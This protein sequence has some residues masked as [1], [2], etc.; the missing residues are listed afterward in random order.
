RVRQVITTLAGEP[1]ALR[2]ISLVPYGAH[3]FDRRTRD[4]PVQAHAWLVPPDQALAV[5]AR[6]EQRGAT[7]AGHPGA[8]QVEDML[9]EVARMLRTDPGRA[10]LL[11]V[12]AHGPHPPRADVSQIL[13]CPARHDWD[14]LLR[15]L[16]GRP[17]MRF[18]AICDDS[19]ASHE[20]WRRLGG[21]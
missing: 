20:V 21:G 9:A 4:E 16:E 6:I 17:G 12:G 8:A 3:S 1:R 2:G 13:P 7:A 18:L 11:S 10:A 15:Y 19:P 14:G 5:L